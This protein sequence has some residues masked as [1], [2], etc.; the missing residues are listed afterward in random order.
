MDI[1]K[2]ECHKS[3]CDC[4]NSEWSIHIIIRSYILP[5]A[6]HLE[7]E[8]STSCFYNRQV[9][10]T[11]TA[12]RAHTTPPHLPL[13]ENWTAALLVGADVDCEDGLDDEI[14]VEEAD[15]PETDNDGDVNGEVADA[16]PA[17]LAELE[18][19][20]TIELLLLLLDAFALDP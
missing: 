20:S 11:A 9:A 18:D 13:T 15:E 3:I 2:V 10:A 7:G 16:V 19:G 12:S 6:S 14:S 1:I 17:W 4:T 5:V 8:L